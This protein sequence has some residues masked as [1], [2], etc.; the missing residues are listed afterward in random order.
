MV[1]GKAAADELEQPFQLTSVEIENGGGSVEAR[2]VA[3]PC[4]PLGA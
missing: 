2:L 4:G 1:P 3:H